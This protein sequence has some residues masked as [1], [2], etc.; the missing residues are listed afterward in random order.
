MNAKVNKSTDAPQGRVFSYLRW[1]SELQTWGDNER[2]QLAMAE[3]WCEQRGLA[4]TDKY[5]DSGVSAYHG[6]NRSSQPV[7][8]VS[9]SSISPARNHFL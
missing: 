9:H 8:P 4:L 3:S 5:R 7:Q 6:R 2:R 1:S